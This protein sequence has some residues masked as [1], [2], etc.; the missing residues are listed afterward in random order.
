M[1]RTIIFAL[2][3]SQSVAH[4]SDPSALVPYALGFL[5]VIC[6]AVGVFTW[7]ATQ[8]LA[9]NWRRFYI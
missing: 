2:S 8:S 3:V 6:V 4:A 7:L 9:N 1:N 5:I